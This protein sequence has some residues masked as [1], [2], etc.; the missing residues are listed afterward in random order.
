MNGKKI[1]YGRKSTSNQA[2][3]F[4]LQLN[5]VQQKF[6]EVDKVY[7]DTCSGGEKLE[8]RYELLKLLDEI[9]K[10][11]IVYVYSLSRISREVFLHL[12][13]EKEIERAGGKIISVKEESSCEDTPEQKM[14]RTILMAFNEYEKSCIRARTRSAK[15]VKR[16]N[17]EYN[18]GVREY[19]YIIE[20]GKMVPNKDE[21]KN[22][23][24]MKEM[25]QNGSKVVD[26][27]RRL[28][29]MGVKST[30]GRDWSYEMVRLTLKRVS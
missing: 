18:G 25:K 30:T 28:N 3:S 20:D 14:M 29:Q 16:Q 13:I 27:Q 8:K 26:I 17:L 9:K 15:K 23:E 6:G 7:F 10:G 4:D 12:Y 5:E 22:L 1:F 24:L 21:Q 2:T 11:D 19:G